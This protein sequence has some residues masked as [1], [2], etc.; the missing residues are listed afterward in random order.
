MARGAANRAV[1]ELSAAGGAAPFPMQN[2]ITGRFRAEAVRVGRGDLQS[3]WMG[4][5][6]RLAV[7][8]DAG[9]VFA[10]LVAG[11]G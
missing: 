4:Q 6:G 8:E 5:S 11:M 7:R 9:E 10:E 2:W 1:R 3:L